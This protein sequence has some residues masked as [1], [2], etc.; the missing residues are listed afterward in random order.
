MTEHAALQV[1]E[2]LGPLD[3]SVLYLR[4]GDGIR[5]EHAFRNLTHLVDGL[6]VSA[7]NTVIPLLPAALAATSDDMG[8]VL[9]NSLEEVFTSHGTRVCI[10]HSL[11][12]IHI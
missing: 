5:T 3:R 12:L 8:T 7:L 11:S 9:A 6:G 4:S 1:D 10:P 2:S